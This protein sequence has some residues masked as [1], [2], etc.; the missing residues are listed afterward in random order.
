MVIERTNALP[1]PSPEEREASRALAR[2]IAEEITAT[3]GW[4]PFSR[5]MEL[6]LYSP[7]LGYY[8]GGAQKFGAAGDF[9]TAPE[10]TPLFGQSLAAQIAELFA[11]TSPVILEVG[12][13]SG[14][15]AADLLAS[16]AALGCAPER[17]S[18]LELSGELRA[19]QKARIAERTPDLVERVQWLDSLPN[20]FDGVVIGNEV[21]DAMPVELAVWR[22]EAILQR[23]VRVEGD[24][25]N[26][27][28]RPAQGLLAREAEKLAVTPP[29]G[30]EYVSEIGLVAQAWIAEWAQR[31]ARGA[32]LLIDYGYPRQEYYLP[33]RSSGTLS[34]YRLHRHHDEPLLWPGLSDITAFVDFT[35]IAEAGFAAGLDVLGYADQAN[36][37]IN[38][39]LLDRLAERGPVDSADYLRAARAAQSLIAPHDMGEAFK[40]IA[41]GRGIRSPLRGFQRGDRLHTL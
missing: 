24:R 22:E 33:T 13:G 38:C 27:E 11:Q 18:I 2:A 12:A 25:F 30:G 28:D 35:A 17:Y 4:I 23:G 6:A 31:L 15:L 1:P 36:F 8:G 20:A 32:L 7:G 37:L 10:L 21:L 34:C 29:V 5:Y 40:V 3:G 19:R 9:I 16:L 14:H 26:W 39:G 41:L